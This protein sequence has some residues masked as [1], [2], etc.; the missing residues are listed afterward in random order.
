MD[1]GY[2][3]GCG[4]RSEDNR[5]LERK[6]LRNRG[7]RVGKLNTQLPLVMEVC[8]TSTHWPQSELVFQYTKDV[9][10]CLGI[11]TKNSL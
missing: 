6:D 11:E 4:K 9:P 8:Q 1:I 3:K 2:P 10:F 5:G 7:K